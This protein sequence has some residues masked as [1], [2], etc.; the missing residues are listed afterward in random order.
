MRLS[1]FFRHC[2]TVFFRNFF[3]CSSHQFLIFCK[4]MD[5]QKIP[6]RPP[7]YIF[8]HCAT[9][10]KLRKNFEKNWNFFFSIFSFLRAFV[11]SSCRKVVF[12]FESFLALDMVPTWAVPGLLKVGEAESSSDGTTFTRRRPNGLIVMGACHGQIPKPCAPPS[13]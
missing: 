4:R 2:E 6:E 12:V 1:S 10:R 5:F 9:Y 11:V 8:R 7:S 13:L 3:Y